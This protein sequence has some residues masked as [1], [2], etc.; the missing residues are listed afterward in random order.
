[1]SKPN[2][3]W[4]AFP[5]WPMFLGWLF[6]FVRASVLF[7][8][9][10]IIS[11]AHRL[12]WP[13][14]NNVRKRT[15]ISNRTEC[16]KAPRTN[17]MNRKQQITLSVIHERFHLTAANRVL[18]WIVCQS[19][20][21]THLVCRLRCEI[22]VCTQFIYLWHNGVSSRSVQATERQTKWY[23]AKLC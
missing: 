5:K 3:K 23:I 6:C 18:L 17:E 8:L 16:K 12:N 2:R 4:W 19:T 20:T 14:V 13:K 22:L 21:E 9:L 15:R 11:R 7:F 10:L 1:M